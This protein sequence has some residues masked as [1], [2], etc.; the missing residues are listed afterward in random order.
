V[1]TASPCRKGGSFIKQSWGM[2]TFHVNEASPTRT[3]HVSK[4]DET[5]EAIL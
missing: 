4:N 2:L 3:L 5:I 1:G